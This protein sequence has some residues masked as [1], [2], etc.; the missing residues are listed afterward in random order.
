MSAQEPRKDI[1]R[2]QLHP[3]KYSYFNSFLTVFLTAG[4][5]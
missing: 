2:N 1:A 5:F 4:K 3:V